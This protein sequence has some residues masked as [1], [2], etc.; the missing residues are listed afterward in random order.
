MHDTCKH[1]HEK[2]EPIPNEPMLRR[3]TSKQAQTTAR[4]NYK[5]IQPHGGVVPMHQK[6]FKAMKN[7]VR[8]AD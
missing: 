3:R 2:G 5:L 8:T 7:N 4:D 1:S 6:V